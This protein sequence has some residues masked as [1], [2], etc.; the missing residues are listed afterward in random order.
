MRWRNRLTPT[1]AVASIQRAPV[2]SAQAAIA[3]S[4]ASTRTWAW[5][6]GGTLTRAA[7]NGT[8][9][10]A[11][12]LQPH[13]TPSTQWHAVLK[14]VRR[15]SLRSCPSRRLNVSVSTKFPVDSMTTTANTPA[16]IAGR[17]HWEATAS[18]AITVAKL[19]AVIKIRRDSDRRPS[20]TGNRVLIDTLA[21]APAHRRACRGTARVRRRSARHI[22]RAGSYARRGISPRSPGAARDRSSRAS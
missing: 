12:K 1:N 2:A 22:R 11:T 19:W 5:R 15:S 21:T 8:N 4:I 16:A 17:P 9:S 10:H 14:I 18:V 20:G 3:A 7:P 6:A 13:S